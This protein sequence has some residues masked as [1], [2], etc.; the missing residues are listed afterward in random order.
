MT[1]TILED[2][3]PALKEIKVCQRAIARLHNEWYNL[4]RQKE[5]FEAVK[6]IYLYK[7]TMLEQSRK[8]T[9]QL[10]QLVKSD[11]D[12]YRTYGTDGYQKMMKDWLERQES[13]L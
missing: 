9:A 10:E 8:L 13:N 7:K 6:Q 12:F 11:E 4:N 2:K 3:C 5:N 1:T